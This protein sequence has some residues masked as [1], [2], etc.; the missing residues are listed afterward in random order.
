MPT[1]MLELASTSPP[2]PL[3]WLACLCARTPLQMRLRHCP[4]HSLRFH[5]PSSSSPWLTILT[6]VE[7]L[8]DMP[9]KPVTILTLVNACPTF[10][11]CCLPSLRSQYPPDTAY[12]PYACSAPLTCLPR[13]PHT[14][15]ILK[16][17]YDPYPPAAPHLC[18]HHPLRFRTPASHPYAP[19]APSRYASNAPQPPLRLILSPLL[20]ILRIRY[21]IHGVR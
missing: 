10:L 9:P 12:H 20:T 4:Q 21:Y 18:P 15:L 8:P 14:G 11:Q 7:C 2:K 19:A 1:L 3:Q 13:P 17:A 5:T 6:V 16:A